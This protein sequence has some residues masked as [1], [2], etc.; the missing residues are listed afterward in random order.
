MIP[1]LVCLAALGLGSLMDWRTR[2]IPI[3]LPVVPILASIWLFP[4]WLTHPPWSGLTTIG[5]AAL[6]F[7][8]LIISRVGWGDVALV[9]PIALVLGV[10]VAVALAASLALGLWTLAWRGRP[11]DPF[12]PHLL[13]GFLIASAARWTVGG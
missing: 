13:V 10:W 9:V 2:R 8:T 11:D 5:V 1:W 3:W 4:D 12:V 7:A 6:A